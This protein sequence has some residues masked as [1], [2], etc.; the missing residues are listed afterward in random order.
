MCFTLCFRSASF[1]Y[2]C[3]GK[4][5]NG[6]H[7][8]KS[9]LFSQF[10][11]PANKFYCFLVGAF[12]SFIVIGVNNGKANATI[13][14]RCFFEVHGKHSVSYTSL[15]NYT[16]FIGLIKDFRT[17]SIAFLRLIDNFLQ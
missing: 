6:K 7:R 3:Q 1:L 5:D 9:S 12:L 2:V 15:M 13:Q 8:L 10:I 16:I 17:L 4:A 14:V 11:Q